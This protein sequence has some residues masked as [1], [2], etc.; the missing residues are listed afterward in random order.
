MT[1][2]LS[3]LAIV[4]AS[5]TGVTVTINVSLTVFPFDVPSITMVATPEELVSKIRFKSSPTNV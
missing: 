1:T 3:A 2:S 4:G 5:S